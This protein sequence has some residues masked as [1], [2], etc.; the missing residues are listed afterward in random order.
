MVLVAVSL[1]VPGCAKLAVG[2]SS[3]RP[4]VMVAPEAVPAELVLDPAIPDNFLIPSTASVN[5][6]PVRSWRQTLDTGYHSAFPSPGTS[7][8]RLQLIEAGLSFAPAAVSM[9]GTAAV[10]ASIRF[11]ARL[12]DSSG[13]EVAKLA[14]TVEAREANVS[15]SEQGMTDNAMKAVEALYEKLAAELLKS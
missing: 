11:K 13:A 3:P 12:V 2:P 7:G 15:P 5:Q 4:N 10:I 6:V 8:R 9:R 14:G 1:L